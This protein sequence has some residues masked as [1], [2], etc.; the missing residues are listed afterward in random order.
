M[1]YNPSLGKNQALL[2][3]HGDR[4]GIT[5]P[6]SLGNSALLLDGIPI[7]GASGFEYTSG[8]SG[9]TALAGGTQSSLTPVLAATVNVLNTVAT[10]S[11]SVMLPSLAGAFPPAIPGQNG[12][13]AISCTVINQGAAAGAVF[14]SSGEQ[15]NIL[16]ANASFA[17]ASSGITNFYAVSSG[18]WYTK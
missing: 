5:A 16:A 2:T 12:G 9:I 6:D 1:A 7:A 11:D 17:V 8:R 4:L 15:I 10:T 14:P 13:K 18:H 3:I